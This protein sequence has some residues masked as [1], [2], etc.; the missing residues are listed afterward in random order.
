MKKVDY[1]FV[2]GISNEYD[3][4]EFFKDA[5]DHPEEEDRMKWRQSIKK[6]IGDTESRRVWKGIKRRDIP[7]D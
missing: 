1:A 2:G 3:H 7:R 6:D 5:W 4:P